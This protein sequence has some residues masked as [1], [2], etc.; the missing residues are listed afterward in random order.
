MR[1]GMLFSREKNPTAMFGLTAAM[2]PMQAHSKYKHQNSSLIFLA[3]ADAEN[4]G[5][6]EKSVL[7][8]MCMGGF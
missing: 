4:V 2:H 7:H 1:Q 5:R 6:G 3:S 8:T